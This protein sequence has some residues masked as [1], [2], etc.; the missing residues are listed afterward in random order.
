MEHCLEDIVNKLVMVRTP[1][2]NVQGRLLEYELGAVLIVEQGDTTMCL[3]KD[4]IA[5]YI[6]DN[7]QRLRAFYRD[8][9]TS[10]AISKPDPS[11]MR[12]KMN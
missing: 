11:V 8:L 4:W 6:I 7:A 1:C 12:R 5:I 9:T 2:G 3:V 10:K